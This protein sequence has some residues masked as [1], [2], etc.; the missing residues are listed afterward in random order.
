MLI[1]CVCWWLLVG[2]E[3]TWI[4]SEIEVVDDERKSA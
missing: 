1:V 3:S 4:E 2:I